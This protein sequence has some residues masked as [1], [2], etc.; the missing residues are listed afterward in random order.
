[1]ANQCGI[2]VHC[3]VCAYKVDYLA[4]IEAIE[5]AVITADTSDNG[6]ASKKVIHHD[7][8]SDI[9]VKCKY[10]KWEGAVPR[11]TREGQKC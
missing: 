11:I 8:I 3:H 7:L 9:S 4:I 10:F 5:N 2:C 6:S 1:M